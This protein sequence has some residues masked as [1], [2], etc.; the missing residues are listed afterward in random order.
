MS[1]DDIVRSARHPMH[2]AHPQ[3]P[4]Q[5]HISSRHIWKSEY[6][7]THRNSRE[8]RAKVQIESRD[9]QTSDPAQRVGGVIVRDTVYQMY[10]PEASAELSFDTGQM[11]RGNHQE[12]G[13]SPWAQ[14]VLQMWQSLRQ[15]EK[16]RST[17]NLSQ[18]W[19]VNEFDKFFFNRPRILYP[20]PAVTSSPLFPSNFKRTSASPRVNPC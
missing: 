19:N 7:G 20:R 10:P 2:R 13:S 6:H 16:S 5:R 8:I 12:R 4:T 3:N 9:D 1:L 14:Q 18:L 17:E 15:N 11:P